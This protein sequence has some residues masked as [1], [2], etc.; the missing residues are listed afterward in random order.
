MGPAGPPQGAKYQL[1]EMYVYG[2]NGSRFMEDLAPKT[3]GEGPSRASMSKKTVTS[4]STASR[5]SGAST[6]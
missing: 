6:S 5:R 2:G 1:D 3:K 4:S